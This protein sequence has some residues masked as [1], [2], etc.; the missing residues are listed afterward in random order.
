MAA[1]GTGKWVRTMHF[2][3][4][5][6]VYNLPDFSISLQGRCC[7]LFPNACSSNAMFYGPRTCAVPRLS[8]FCFGCIGCNL[9][10]VGTTVRGVQYT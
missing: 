3:F 9:Y 6:D 8:R 1:D 10:S 5:I 4:E 7:L 2:V